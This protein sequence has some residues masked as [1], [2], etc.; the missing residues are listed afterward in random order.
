[1]IPRVVP[2]GRS[3]SRDWAERSTDMARIRV[4][5]THAPVLVMKRRSY[6]KDVVCT[7]LPQRPMKP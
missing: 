1:M 4:D 3:P 6:D 7:V 2:E 5:E